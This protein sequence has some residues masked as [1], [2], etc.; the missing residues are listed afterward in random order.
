MRRLGVRIS[1]HGS[2][3]TF[4]FN[5]LHPIPK[6]RSNLI[7]QR[8]EYVDDQLVV[9]SSQARPTRCACSATYAEP[10]GYCRCVAVPLAVDPTFEVRDAL[11][12]HLAAKEDK[13]PPREHLRFQFARDVRDDPS[14]REVAVRVVSASGQGSS[15]SGGS[16]AGGTPVTG[17][18]DGAVAKATREASSECRTA[19]VGRL[20]SFARGGGGCTGERRGTDEVV[21]KAKVMELLRAVMFSLHKDGALHFSDKAEDVYVLL[22]RSRVLQPGVEA[23]CRELGLGLTQENEIVR[24]LQGS[25]LFHHVSGA[26]IRA[27]VH[28]MKTS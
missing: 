24:A 28:R 5:A 20:G 15:S 12:A 21:V 17:R 8:S 6:P 27:C 9:S 14:L 13:L 26:R 16:W 18:Q 19:A 25:A 3:Q 1:P 4:I 22:S 7:T 2:R 10:V 23:V 11:L